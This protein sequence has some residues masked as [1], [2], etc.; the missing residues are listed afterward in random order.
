M[1]KPVHIGKKGEKKEKPSGER[2]SKPEGG[3]PPREIPGQVLLVGILCGICVVCALVLGVADLLTQ[4][5]IAANQEAWGLGVLAEVLPYGERYD[6]VD[7]TG[8]DTSV[9][10]VYHAEGVGYA[11]RVSPA[12]S[13]SGELTLMV[14]VNE[15]GTVAGVAVVASKET[16]GLGDRAREPA[17]REQFLGRKGSVRIQAD[18]GDISAI[19]GATVTSRAVCAAVNSALAAAAELG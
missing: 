11:F 3:K 5:R 8:S 2:L 14:G 6:K 19:S 12:G 7:Y 16:E 10:E 15:D 17:F 9:E 13:F 4:D 18:S 1:K